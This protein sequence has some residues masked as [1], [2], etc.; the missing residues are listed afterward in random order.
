M[1]ALVNRLGRSGIDFLSDFGRSGIFLKRTLL[2]MPRV[3]KSFPYFLEQIY[4]VGV[5]SLPII[6]VSGL[7]VGM[8]IGLQGY[9]TLE[10][11]GAEDELGKLLALSIV[12]ELG[13][14]VTALLFAGRAGSALTAEIGLMKTT[15]QLASMEMMDV[16]PLWRII[17]PRFWAGSS[18]CHY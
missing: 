7:F 15:E 9:N 2:R 10:R 18:Q 5:L 6:V 8:V 11:F 1:I 12:R 16:D 17:A 13:P 14:V 4:A 3:R